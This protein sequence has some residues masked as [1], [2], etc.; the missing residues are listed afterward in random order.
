MAFLASLVRPA[1]DPAHSAVITLSGPS[2]G[3]VAQ[4]VAQQLGGSALRLSTAAPDAAAFMGGQA[5]TR[6]EKL[7]RI[8]QAAAWRQHSGLPTVIEV[9]NDGFL[10]DLHAV[11]PLSGRRVS[12][13]VYEPLRAV[14]EKTP[15]DRL[16][17]T[18]LHY[19]LLFR[20]SNTRSA[21]T[22]EALS[23]A[24]LDEAMKVLSQRV[25]AADKL[26]VGRVH[27]FLQSATGLGAHRSVFLEP[28][29]HYDMVLRSENP[30]RSARQLLSLARQAA[31]PQPQQGQWRPELPPACAIFGD[32][33]THAVTCD[34]WMKSALVALHGSNLRLT[35]SPAAWQSAYQK[36]GYTFDTVQAWALLPDANPL[37]Q[38]SGPN[39]DKII[40]SVKKGTFWVDPSPPVLLSGWKYVD[41]EQ[42]W[43]ST[44][45]S[46]SKQGS[47]EDAAFHFSDIQQGSLGDCYLESALALIAGAHRA[48]EMFTRYDE[49]KVLVPAR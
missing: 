27:S 8:A 20:G 2:V 4:E 48:P 22:L 13:L 16:L 28:R 38:S 34:T 23:S 6:L 41:P 46:L 10:H 29:Y 25:P 9:P 32:D 39:Y 45:I 36:A 5:A 12:A 17:A 42:L 1:S 37:V 31:S 3:T 49:S 43:P 11:S 15:A 21:S 18:V 35:Y 30:S 24:A 47:G 44:S 14:V 7:H 33:S 19:G 40:K 26:F